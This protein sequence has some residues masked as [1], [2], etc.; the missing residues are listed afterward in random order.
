M[1]LRSAG[2]VG[3]G[4]LVH[5]GLHSVLHRGASQLPGRVA[6]A[7]DPQLIAHLREK[8]VKGSIRGKQSF[9]S[10]FMFCLANFGII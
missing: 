4:R 5:L 10:Y 6:L 2:A 9:S 7:I 3:A 8:A 1:E